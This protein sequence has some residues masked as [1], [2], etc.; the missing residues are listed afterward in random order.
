MRRKPKDPP[1][2]PGNEA[3][4]RTFNRGLEQVCKEKG[5]SRDDLE[6]RRLTPVYD[7]RWARR[8]LALRLRAIRKARGL[9]R[10]QVARIANVPPRLLTAAERGED[11]RIGA[12]ELMRLCLALKYNFLKF[13]DEVDHLRKELK[14]EGSGG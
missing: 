14:A 6:R 11:S 2:Y 3:V 8:A 5:M 13:L 10:L 7:P 9:T 12:G 1:G 4:D